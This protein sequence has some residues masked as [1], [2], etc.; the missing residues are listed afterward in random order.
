MVFT[1]FLAC[2][3]EFKINNNYKLKKK[4]QTSVLHFRPKNFQTVFARMMT[5]FLSNIK[6]PGVY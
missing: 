4:T 3:K 1:A 6:D 2:S 5:N